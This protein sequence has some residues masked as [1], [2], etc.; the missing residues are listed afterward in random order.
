MGIQIPRGRGEKGVKG[1]MIL[2]DKIY[3]LGLETMN[4]LLLH[5]NTTK[6]TEIT[7]TEAGILSEMIVSVGGYPLF[8]SFKEND[9]ADFYRIWEKEQR[10][11]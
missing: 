5:R 3:K 2:E 8:I 7:L 1:N 10:K 6:K 11:Q 9:I 4:E